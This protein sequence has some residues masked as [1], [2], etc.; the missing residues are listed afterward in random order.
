MDF[1]FLSCSILLNKKRAAGAGLHLL[2]EASG[3]GCRHTSSALR[4]WCVCATTVARCVWSLHPCGGIIRVRF[5]GYHL[6]VGLLASAPRVSFLRCKVSELI[7]DSGTFSA[8]FFR[9]VQSAAFFPRAVR[10]PK[11]APVCAQIV[12]ASEHKC[13]TNNNFSQN[14]LAV[15]AKHCTFVGKHYL[16]TISEQR[17]I[18]DHTYRT[19][20]TF[21]VH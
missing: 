15:F 2:L 4:R 3:G 11:I 1:P 20:Y 17:L 14:A 7:R 19:Y 12:P 13:K 18:H 6:S 5:Y 8:F 9:F 21:Y 16:R 10:Q